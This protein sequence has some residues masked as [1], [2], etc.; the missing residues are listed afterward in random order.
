MDKTILVNNIINEGKTLLE[1]L[2]KDNI[3]VH[4]A[5]WVLDEESNKWRLILSSPFVNEK[6]PLAFQKLLNK[7]IYEDNTKNL[8]Y[9]NI[10]VYPTN[11]DLI[12]SL[13]SIHKVKSKFYNEN[14]YQDSYIYFLK[15]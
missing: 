1:K 11:N 3:K 8:I 12:K 15:N 5:L 13:R 10:S 4:D 14:P 9:N 7:Y 6:G 2:K